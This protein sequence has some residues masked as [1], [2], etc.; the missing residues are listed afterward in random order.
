MGDHSAHV[1]EIVLQVFNAVAHCSRAAYPQ[2]ELPLD[3]LAAKFSSTEILKDTT[4]VSS[5]SQVL[6]T[7]VVDGWL[8]ILAEFNFAGYD[9]NKLA[10]S[11]QLVKLV[12]VVMAH[13]P[14]ATIA[15]RASHILRAFAQNR[16][17]CP[18]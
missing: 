17:C 10:S 18:N 8:I 3:A 7:L 5:L 9:I 1:T 12:D 15:T 6:D 13:H 16:I 2:A 11:A 4:I 14:D